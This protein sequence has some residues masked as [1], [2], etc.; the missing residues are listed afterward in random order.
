MNN[1]SDPEK[2]Q[3][4]QAKFMGNVKLKISPDEAAR[5]YAR[6]FD[7][8]SINKI[9]G[10]WQNGYCF[11][12]NEV[13]DRWHEYIAMQPPKPIEVKSNEIS[14]EVY[15]MFIRE[16]IK[17]DSKGNWWNKLKLWYKFFKA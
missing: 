7:E 16:K 6:Q 12:N 11:G 1:D 14:L 13:M 15:K 17:K 9:I 2:I 10:A 3:A 8:A 4:S 5:N